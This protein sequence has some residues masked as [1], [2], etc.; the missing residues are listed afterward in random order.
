MPSTPGPPIEANSLSVMPSPEIMMVF[1]PW[2]RIWRT[3]RP[4]S[5]CRPPHI[6]VV[7]AGGLDLG[8]DRRI[9]LLADVDAFVEDFLLAAG[10]HE[11]ARG[12][13]EPLAVGGLV[14]DDGDLLV[15]EIAE[16]QIGPQLAL[17][18]VAAAGAEGVPQLAVGDLGIGRRGGDEQDVVVG[19]DFGGGDGDAGVE[20]ADDEL[21]AVADELVGDRDALLGI[22]D[23]VARLDLDLLAENAAGG[24]DVGGG[25]I[26]P[27][28]QLRAERGVGAGDRAGDADLDV[29]LS[30]AAEQAARRQRQ[31]LRRIVSF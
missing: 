26:D 23:V 8:D 18:V 10:V 2:S 13:G 16:R 19:I 27:L 20:V 11:A 28:G 6:R 1:M 12:V 7:G 5:V 15:L 14:V 9:V 3:I 21:D 22:G 4:A 31:A 29:G 25:L 24:V 17:L 30:A